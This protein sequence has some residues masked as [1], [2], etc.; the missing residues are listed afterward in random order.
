MWRRKM[1]ERD[2]SW[3]QAMT[4]LLLGSSPASVGAAADG[5]ETGRGAVPGA[6]G[7]GARS[8]PARALERAH[9]QT[10]LEVIDVAVDGG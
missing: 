10:G 7:A 8:D 2:V 5:R 9:R 3:E 6:L 1:R 4:T